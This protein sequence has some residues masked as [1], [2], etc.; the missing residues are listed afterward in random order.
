MQNRLQEHIVREREP[1][2]DIEQTEKLKSRRRK[3][4]AI[5]AVSAFLLAAPVGWFAYYRQVESPLDALEKQGN[6]ILREAIGPAWFR[7][8]AE[9]WKLPVP[10][11]IVQFDSS[12]AT[13]EDLAIVAKERSLRV[14]FLVL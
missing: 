4:L 6:S 2:S 1:E 7:K 3:R 8:Y 11:Q 10:K 13:N 5:F 12:T 9:K 14:L